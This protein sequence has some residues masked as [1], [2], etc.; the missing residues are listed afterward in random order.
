MCLFWLA[1]KCVCVCIPYLCVRDDGDEITNV[2]ANA[3]ALL[4]PQRRDTLYTYNSERRISPRGSRTRITYTRKGKQSGDFYKASRRRRRS[5]ISHG[6]TGIFGFLSDGRQYSLLCNGIEPDT[7]FSPA[8][9][10]LLT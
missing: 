2:E 5:L 1:R 7:L 8:H 4:K 9:T 10:K 6:R 3:S